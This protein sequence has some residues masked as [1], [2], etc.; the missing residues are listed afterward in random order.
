MVS[1]VALLLII[2][3][4]V[5]FVVYSASVLK[6]HPFLA[7]LL[8]TLFTGFAV[9]MPL[10]Q[11]LESINQGFGSL[12][13]SIGMV[14]VLGS[15]IGVALEKS[16]AAVQIAN[17][18]VRIVGKR[19]PA[20][21]MGIIGAVVGIPVFCD[22]GF[23]ILS[24]LARALAKKT[25][26][27]FSVLAL[28][29]AGGLYTTHV[30]VPPTPGP[31]ACAGNLGLADDL[32]M[33]I[34]MGLLVSIPS[35][36]IAV[37]YGKYI[38]AAFDNTPFEAAMEEKPQKE[39]EKLPSLFL[40]LLP[41]F[42]P[43]ILIAIASFSNIFLVSEGAKEWMAFIGSPLVALLFGLLCA[44]LLFP[45][46]DKKLLTELMGGGI[47]QAGP[48]LILTGAGGSFGALLK[49]TPVAD[50][51]KEWVGS[52]DAE[53]VW[54]LV[55]GYLI[56]ALLKTAQGSSTSALIITSSILAPLLETVGLNTPLEISLLVMSIGGGAMTVSHA[57][58]S[59][60]WVV[61]QFGNFQ[62]KEGYQGLT[63]LT[64]LQG[65][66][67]LMASVLIYLLFL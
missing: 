46:W 14:V 41:I 50:L 55:I 18:V 5:I 23:I 61:A 38:W 29:L 3:I 6:L 25:G 65:A 45:K 34:L 52:G 16:G 43:V 31:L 1:G 28:S 4:A 27:K 30:L 22:S 51:V 56:A 66:T 48:I 35:T 11:I 59:F 12:L 8:A 13:G 58:D 15:T 24:G 60:F 39:E 37:I 2:L 32:G 19:R 63:L 44:F 17:G 53:G 26:K 10:K 20:L 47:S 21:A 9:K 33:V 57:N 36:A 42:L 64:L 62:V 49:A 67:V 40:S 54:I 7:L